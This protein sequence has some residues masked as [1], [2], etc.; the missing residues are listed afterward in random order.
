MSLTEKHIFQK[1]KNLRQDKMQKVPYIH[2]LSLR[3]ELMQS[4]KR[5]RSSLKT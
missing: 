2:F 1:M 5:E 4:F 3:R